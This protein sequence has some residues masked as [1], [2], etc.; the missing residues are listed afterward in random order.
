MGWG[1]KVRN[2]R[3]RALF[4]DPNPGFKASSKIKLLT[5][6]I[7]MYGNIVYVSEKGCIGGVGGKGS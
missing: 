5:D 1:V 3:I 2:V 6:K 4:P 7:G